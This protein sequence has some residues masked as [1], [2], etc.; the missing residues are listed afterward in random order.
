ML[1]R[2]GDLGGGGVQVRYEVALQSS[3][4]RF[5]PRRS[6]HVLLADLAGGKTGRGTSYYSPPFR[7]P[8]RNSPHTDT[9]GDRC[10]GHVSQR[11]LSTL[12][13]P[14]NI[15]ELENRG[16]LSAAREHGAYIISLRPTS[17]AIYPLSSRQSL[18]P[19]Y[20]C[21]FA[22]RMRR[23]RLQ[24]GHETRTPEGNKNDAICMHHICTIR[25]AI[26]MIFTNR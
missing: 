13:T 23:T 21:R 17:A 1:V 16:H 9:L 5:V 18:Q 7:A 11:T 3:V 24:P 15:R 14:R 8:T 4:S 19:G 12:E 6:V 26:I 2:K 20:E 22:Y 25:H 10:R